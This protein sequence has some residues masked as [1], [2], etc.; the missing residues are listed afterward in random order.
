MN[1]RDNLITKKLLLYLILNYKI[2][3]QVMTMTLRLRIVGRL[4]N[5]LTKKT[6]KK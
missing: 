6:F 3:T 4:Q 5:V 1:Q 2:H